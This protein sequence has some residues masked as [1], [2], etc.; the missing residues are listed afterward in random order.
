MGINAIKGFAKGKKKPTSE[1]ENIEE[2]ERKRSKKLRH[3][4]KKKSK[5]KKHRHY[6]EE[7]LDEQITR[8]E[9]EIEAEKENKKSQIVET[10]KRGLENNIE[11]EPSKVL[12]K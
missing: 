2:E 7:T 6:K 5:K 4:K 11:V 10:I 9:K 8:A 12:K 3:K 1:K